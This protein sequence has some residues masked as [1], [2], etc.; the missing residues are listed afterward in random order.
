MNSSNLYLFK[1][2][3]GNFRGVNILFCPGLPGLM[4]DRKIFDNLIDLGCDIYT[5]YYSG[6]YTQSGDFGIEK[7]KDDLIKVL[8]E[9]EKKDKPFIIIGYS[10]STYFLQTINLSEYNNILAVNYFSPILGLNKKTINADFADEIQNLYNSKEVIY[11]TDLNTVLGEIKDAEFDFLSVLNKQTLYNFPV[12]YIYSNNDTIIKVDEIGE[13]LR[14]FK[15]KNTYNSF[16]QLTSKEGYHGLDSYY[17]ENIHAYLEGLLIANDIKQMLDCDTYIY[18]WGSQ[19]ISSSYKASDIDLLVFT[20]KSHL[21]YI[22]LLR[23]YQE[24]YESKAHFKFDLSINDLNDIFDGKPYRFN[25][26]ATITN[27]LKYHYLPI[28]KIEYLPSVP[29][30]ELLQDAYQATQ[31]NLNEAKKILMKTNLKSDRVKKIIKFFKFSLTYLLYFRGI[32]NIDWANISKYYDENNFQDNNK[33]TLLKNVNDLIENNYSNIDIKILEECVL[34]ISTIVNEQEEVLNNFSDKNPYIDKSIKSFY[35]MRHAEKEKQNSY[36]SNINAD[37][38]ITQFGKVKTQYVANYFKAKKITNI[39]CSN[40]TRAIQ[41]AKIVAETLDKDYQIEENLHEKIFSTYD[42]TKEQS[43]EHYNKTYNDWNYTNYGGES[44]NA[45]V[46][47][48]KSGIK[49]ILF[50]EKTGKPLLVSH[51]RVMQSFFAGLD[52]FSMNNFELQELQIDFCEVYEVFYKLDK[53]T[54]SVHY[55]SVKLVI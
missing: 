48:L 7:S 39:Y 41:T 40:Y 42:I 19:I 44:I 1:K 35:I 25:R 18:F 26:G 47:R 13:K 3:T 24:N 55:I 54:K 8:E 33:L 4:T 30:Y 2:H 32:D 49:N 38:S 31:T 34:E 15:D 28:Y 17:N 37:L 53:E 9:M 27:E 6:T 29:K 50:Q 43:L 23:T 22:E 52:N 11:N 36:N 5:F 10:Y 51:G 45:G 46:E 20:S 14:K 12:S 16:L 21:K